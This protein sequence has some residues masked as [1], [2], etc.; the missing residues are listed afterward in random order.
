MTD[1]GSPPVARFYGSPRESCN[2]SSVFEDTDSV[3]SDAQ[4]QLH[5]MVV[6]SCEQLNTI[7]FQP[8]RG[9]EREREGD[10]RGKGGG[11][12]GEGRGKGGERKGKG[13]GRKGKGRSRMGGRER[14]VRQRVAQTI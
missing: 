2:D 6:P 3:A 12:E 9:R 13:R 8:A 7:E 1:N 5:T 11:R 10:R 4:P 14:E